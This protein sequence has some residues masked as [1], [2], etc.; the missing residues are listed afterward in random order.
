MALKAIDLIKNCGPVEELQKLIALGCPQVA[1]ERPPRTRS[2]FLTH[3][4]IDTTFESNMGVQ[5]VTEDE[6][7]LT[8][9]IGSVHKSAGREAYFE[10][11]LEANFEP[12]SNNYRG[13]LFRHILR[14]CFYRDNTA[15]HRKFA[16]ILSRHRPAEIQNFALHSYGWLDDLESLAF[17]NTLGI[18]NN[19]PGLLDNALS[20]IHCV[21]PKGVQGRVDV[22]KQLLA[23]GATLLNFIRPYM[24]RDV[25]ATLEANDKEVLVTVQ[26]M[27]DTLVKL[28]PCNSESNAVVC[29]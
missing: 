2:K 22:V 11:L 10:L 24:M 4:V 25:L 18:P 19:L 26:Q 29:S 1:Y 8:A 15:Q 23:D 9:V 28:Q 6:T 17:L 16:T 12:S 14:G 13:H 27:H 7:R 20:Y 5:S 21:A 3:Y